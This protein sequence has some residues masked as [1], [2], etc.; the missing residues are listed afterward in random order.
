MGIAASLE[1]LYAYTEDEGQT[2]SRL[3]RMQA[4][5]AA[6]RAARRRAAGMHQEQGSFE[7]R[8]RS[9]TAA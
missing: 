8:R 5:Q 2:A 3:S 4:E 1:E 9:Q 7:G 6:K